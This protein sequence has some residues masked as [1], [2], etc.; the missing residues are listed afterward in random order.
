M[1]KLTSEYHRQK[2]LSRK[3]K[4]DSSALFP[5]AL[6]R[7]VVEI[8]VSDF[9][10]DRA[11]I[12]HA[13]LGIE[14]ELSHRNFGM[15]IRILS[16]LA[17]VRIQAVQSVLLMRGVPNHVTSID[18]D[19]IWTRRRSGQRVFSEHFGF[20][21]KSANLAAD[22]FAEPHDAVGIHLKSLRLALRRRIE[23]G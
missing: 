9:V 7:S 10:V 16:H 18:A 8:E 15:R 17:S 1:R 13:S 22:S 6:G 2:E 21:I 11:C 5:S 19:G 14:K 23:F 20:G 12:P 4:V 3:L